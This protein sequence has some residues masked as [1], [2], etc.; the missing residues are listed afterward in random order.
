VLKWIVICFIAGVGLI[1]ASIVAGLAGLTG[2]AGMTTNLAWILF[3][4]GV[5]LSLVQS[6]RHSRIERNNRVDRP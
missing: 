6:F 2:L 5:V 4:V 1:L 3:G